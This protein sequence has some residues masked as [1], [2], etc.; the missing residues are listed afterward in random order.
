MIIK[1]LTEE[2]LSEQVLS[3][4]KK[5]LKKYLNNTIKIL[6]EDETNTLYTVKTSNNTLRGFINN[7]QELDLPLTSMDCSIVWF[8]T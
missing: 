7:V 6:S 8:S 2:Y 3:L 5:V 1:E 4:S